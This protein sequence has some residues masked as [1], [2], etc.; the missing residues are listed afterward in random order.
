ME[1][2][3]EVRISSRNVYT[4]Y[5]R[6]FKEMLKD[7]NTIEYY[8]LGNAIENAVRAAEML[9][10]LG[11]ATLGK[12]NTLSVLELDRSGVYRTRNKVIIILVKASGFDKAYNDFNSSR[13]TKKD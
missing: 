8:A 7:N 2:N 1:R 9:C 10:S 11:F 12:F 4:I 5:V 6:A 13:P 3:K